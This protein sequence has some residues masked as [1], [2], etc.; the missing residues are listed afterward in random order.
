MLGC[1]LMPLQP[2]R[3]FPSPTIEQWRH[4]SPIR[5]R[6]PGPQSTRFPRRRAL[7]S[8]RK[9]TR[10]AQLRLSVSFTS[11]ASTLPPW[12]WCGLL[13]SPGQ[14]VFIFR[15]GR[16]S[17]CGSLP[18]RSTLPTAC[19]TLALAVIAEPA[20]ALQMPA[21]FRTGTI[22]IGVIAE[23]WARWPPH[24]PLLRPCLYLLSCRPHP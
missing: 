23:S 12:R 13:L 15:S 19:W 16:P 14:P 17:R 11:P 20:T 6:Q 18:G 1:E 2:C 24:P 7:A 5:R 8:A 3:L 4:P 21:A 22:S 10:L 9:V